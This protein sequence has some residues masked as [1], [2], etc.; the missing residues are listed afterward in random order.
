MLLARRSRWLLTWIAVPALLLASCSSNQGANS[1]G[2][3]TVVAAFYPIQEAASRVGG[4][5]VQ[6]FNLT[7]PGAEPHDLELTP[8]GVEQIQSADVVMY[9]GGGFQP[10]LEDALSGAEGETVD[11][12]AGLDTLPPPPG[13][14]AEG[15]S[16]DPHVW[17]APR[18]YAE[19]VNEVAEA[20]AKADPDSASTFRANAKAF[21]ADIDQ[22]DLQYQ[23][24]LAHC[25]R[26]IIVTS[27]EAF[28][29]LA[30]AYG[31]TQE[32]ITGLSPEAEPGPARLAELKDLV[33]RQGI[34]TIFTEELVSPK[35]AQTLARE[36]GVQTKVLSTLEG[37]TPEE[38]AAG[39]DYISLMLD[40]LAT[41]EKALD[42]S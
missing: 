25:Q 27:H 3:K 4:G 15:L 7:P 8:D 19:M 16:V 2:S 26:H 39:E 40:N 37:L 12:L 34:T 28:G 23:E 41:L 18:L 13:E 1:P 22:V 24:G 31:L 35:V 36:A 38:Q 29:Y 30:S 20:L 6:V 32:A 42:C 9:L 14:A 10:A 21:E 5:A 33:Q 17:L 11:L